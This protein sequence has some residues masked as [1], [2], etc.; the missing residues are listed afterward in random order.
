VQGFVFDIRDV[1]PTMDGP[2][3]EV[4]LVGVRV[5]TGDLAVGD[6]VWV[7]LR[8]G[9]RARAECASF[10]LIRFVDSSWRAI[11]VT[12][13]TADAVKIGGQATGL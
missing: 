2:A 3:G 5:G 13:V 6:H 9:G 1:F 12:G 10:P 8:D 7:P 4:T 11:S